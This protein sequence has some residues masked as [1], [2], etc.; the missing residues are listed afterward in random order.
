MLVLENCTDAAA[1]V[2]KDAMELE[3]ATVKE[4]YRL[5]SSADSKRRQ[6]ELAEAVSQG[7]HVS[8][9]S[10]NILCLVKNDSPDSFGG[11]TSLAAKSESE[12]E[13]KL[14]SATG[15]SIVP[16]TLARKSSFW[17]GTEYQIV[18]ENVPADGPQYRYR[19]LREKNGNGVQDLLNLLSGKAYEVKGMTRDAMGITVLMEKTVERKVPLIEQKETMDPH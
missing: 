13:T 17:S 14:N 10:G 18:M 11:Y 5:L 15:Y 3:E 16:E 19:V 12:L 9:A 7:F 6:K 1:Q 2:E 8:H 4:R